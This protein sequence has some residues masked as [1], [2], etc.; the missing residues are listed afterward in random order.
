M[1]THTPIKLESTPVLAWD[2]PARPIFER[3]KRWYV[4]AGIIVFV[5]AAYGIFSGS[6]SLS[7]VCVLAGGM[8]ALIH[9]HQPGTSHVE[10]HDSGI[11]L[12][13][14][15]TRWDEFS[16]YWILNTPTYSELRFVPKRSGHGRKAIQI[17]GQDHNQLRMILGQRLP[18][19]TQM[20]E[21]LIDIF[22]RLCKL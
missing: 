14:V 1:H 6:W 15:F 8:Y 22:V 16:G 11:V 3:T 13:N 2:A 20:K 17:V 21:S 9:D 12:E 5:A 18:E 7:I 10:L 19:L 4:V